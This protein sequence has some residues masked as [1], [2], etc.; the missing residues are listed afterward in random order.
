MNLLLTN[1]RYL[2]VCGF[3]FTLLKYHRFLLIGSKQHIFQ[4]NLWSPFHFTRFLL[5]MVSTFCCDCYTLFITILLLLLVILC[6][7]IL[8]HLVNLE[9]CCD[10]YTLFITSW[11]GFGSC[12]G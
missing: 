9:L 4:E 8:D 2:G 7:C 5:L 3:I 12:R 10:C 11:K 1:R 6:F